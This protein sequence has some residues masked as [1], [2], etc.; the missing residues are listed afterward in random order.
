MCQAEYPHMQDEDQLSM[1]KPEKAQAN[2]ADAMKILIEKAEHF[3]YIENQF[4]V[5]GFGNVGAEM[6]ETFSGPGEIVYK[7]SSDSK[8]EALEMFTK[9]IE[10]K[11]E[12]PVYPWIYV[13]E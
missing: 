12:T 4:F 9:A 10:S 6:S 7:K 5:S 1:S 2:I 3:I 11:Y 8:K 13:N